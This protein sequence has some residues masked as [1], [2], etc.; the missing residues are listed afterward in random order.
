[1]PS[2]DARS[3]GEQEDG[4]LVGIVGEIK[5]LA[6]RLARLNF[7]GLISLLEAQRAQGCCRID[8]ALC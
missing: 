6:R 8:S 7:H 3:A 4:R 2:L 5:G 1:V